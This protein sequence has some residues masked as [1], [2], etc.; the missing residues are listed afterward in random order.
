MAL[1]RLADGLHLLPLGAVNAYLLDTPCGLAL[2]DAGFPDKA[3]LVLQ[4]LRELGKAPQDLRHIVLTHAHP[5]HV[6]S[7]AAL[8]RSTGA[9]TWMHALD[10]PIAERG[11]GFRPMRPAPGLLRGTL[12]RLFVRPGQSVEPATIDHAMQD[13]DL[14]P[15]AGGLRVCHAPGHCL[16]QVALLWPD[17]GVLF[18]GD[19]VANLMGI[20]DPL[21]FEDQAEG[22]RSQARLAALD[23]RIACFGHGKPILQDAGDRFRRRFG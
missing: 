15:V 9:A 19:A 20:G 1:Q 22:R 17:R 12:F 2:I 8:V 7:L 5:D 13:G 18:A 3:D 11:T 10:I 16:G 4:A 23:F 6:G 21:G 14:L